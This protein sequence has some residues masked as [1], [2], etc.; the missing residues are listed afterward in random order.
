MSLLCSPLVAQ[1]GVNST[2][3]AKAA[4][5]LF[6][7]GLAKWGA[8]ELSKQE[9][10]QDFSEKTGV[11]AHDV[12]N[13]ITISGGMLSLSLIANK[14]TAQGLQ[15][16]SWR[17]SIAAGVAGIVC[18]KTFQNIVKHVPVIGSCISCENKGCEGLCSNC[19]LTKITL[20]IG[21]YRAVDVGLQVLPSWLSQLGKK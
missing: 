11:Q 3:M 19:K 8:D 20:A 21:V 5:G 15:N 10:V 2:N 7:S 13:V 18:T 4:G 6:L 16:L 12:G 9:I 1:D 17:A 14:D